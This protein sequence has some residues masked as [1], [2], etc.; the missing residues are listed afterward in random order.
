MLSDKENSVDARKKHSEN[1]RYM[2]ALD[3]GFTYLFAMTSNAP[4]TPCVLLENSLKTHSET[5][6]KG[7]ES[8]N[9][10]TSKSEY[11]KIEKYLSGVCS[12]ILDFCEKHKIERI[13]VGGRSIKNPFALKPDVLKNDM[14]L[15]VN[16]HFIDKLRF[17]GLSCGVDVF[18]IDETNTSQI[19][20]LAGE[21]LDKKIGNRKKMKTTGEARLEKHIFV[22]KTGASIDRDIHAAINIGRRAFGN[23]FMEVLS[24]S[25]WKRPK[26]IVVDY[27]NP[28][29]YHEKPRIKEET[30]DVPTIGER[31]AKNKTLFSN[32]GNLDEEPFLYPDNPSS[33]THIMKNIIAV[34]GEMSAL[35]YVLSL[36]IKECSSAGM[37]IEISSAPEKSKLS[38]L[39]VE[40]REAPFISDKKT[41]YRRDLLSVI[42]CFKKTTNKEHK[43]SIQ[44]KTN[45]FIRWAYD[46]T[47]GYASSLDD[48]IKNLR[49]EYKEKD[50][51]DFIFSSFESGGSVVL[52]EPGKKSKNGISSDE[53]TKKHAEMM[54]IEERKRIL[55]TI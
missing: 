23:M 42:D 13:A 11:E 37:D 6:K 45:L 3:T 43:K 18:I 50:F 21:P 49:S 48:M 10:E 7:I 36:A 32:I 25:E 47:K 27:E 14:N 54:K 26:I 20:A 8:K 19:D 29:K 34:A 39:G 46:K 16:I 53:F 33:L 1:G 30:D 51:H 38:S 5:I 24:S 2:A 44:L 15:M 55:S 22:S 4:G 52:K 35:K 31:I 40:F 12:Y 17:L 28:S 9:K 41:E